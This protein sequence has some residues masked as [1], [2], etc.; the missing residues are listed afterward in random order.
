[1][2]SIPEKYKQLSDEEKAVFKK[3]ALREID[4][5]DSTFHRKMRIPTSITVLEKQ[6][7]ENFFYDLQTSKI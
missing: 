2:A 7:L 3:R 1:M 6:Q 4:W 5:S